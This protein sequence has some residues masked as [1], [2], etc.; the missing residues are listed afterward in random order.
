MRKSSAILAD[1]TTNYQT[2]EKSLKM[3]NQF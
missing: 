3:G 2:I 1:K